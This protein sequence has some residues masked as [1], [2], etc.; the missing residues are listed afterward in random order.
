MMKKI[1]VLNVSL[2][3]LQAYFHVLLV[4]VLKIE[5]PPKTWQCRFVRS[6]YPVLQCSLLLCWAEK[7]HG[8]LEFF[9][10]LVQYRMPFLRELHSAYKRWTRQ[11]RL[12]RQNNER[13]W[14]CLNRP[15]CCTEG[16]L[17]PPAAL[18]SWRGR[19]PEGHRG[20]AETLGVQG[21]DAA[22]AVPD[23]PVS[24]YLL[25]ILPFASGPF[26]RQVAKLATR[27]VGKLSV[28]LAVCDWVCFLI[29][30]S[31]HLSKILA[32]W[33]FQILNGGGKEG[34]PYGQENVLEV[35]I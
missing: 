9:E 12:N 16:S 8:G 11:C 13:G 31:L 29:S 34:Q 2:L 4:F 21:Q 28:Q 3:L 35:K 14:G 6:A 23:S 7:A 24:T 10:L 5:D 1:P 19:L 25:L 18:R 22:E 20:H 26:G 17:H 27:S 15:A 32:G 30:S 33:Y